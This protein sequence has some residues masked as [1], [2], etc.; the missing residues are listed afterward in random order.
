MAGFRA[1]IP[2][3]LDRFIVIQKLSLVLAGV[4]AVS[5]V[6]MSF[7]RRIGMLLPSINSRAR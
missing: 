4:S 1:G 3:A 2:F 5:G 7:S 6:M